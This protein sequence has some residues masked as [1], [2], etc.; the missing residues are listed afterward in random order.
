MHRARL[1]FEATPGPHRYMVV[2]E[3]ADFLDA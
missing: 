3:A 2:S 1:A